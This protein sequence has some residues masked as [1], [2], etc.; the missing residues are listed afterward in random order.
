MHVLVRFL[1]TRCEMLRN[2]D[3]ARSGHFRTTLFGTGCARPSSNAGIYM[4][5]LTH[6]VQR[7]IYSCGRTYSDKIQHDITLQDYN[8]D[9]TQL[10]NTHVELQ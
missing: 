1:M 9:S 8:V 5:L 3:R 2:L 4:N 6:D 10:E 7:G